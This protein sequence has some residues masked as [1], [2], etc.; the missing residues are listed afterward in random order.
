[1]S[2]TALVEI[3]DV[4]KHFH[5]RRDGGITALDGVSLTI[6]PGESFGLVGESGSGKSTL[7]RCALRL[8][9][10]DSGTISFDGMDLA[11]L[12]ASRLRR[13]RARMQMVFQDPHS[14]LNR[15]YPVGSIIESPLKAHGIGSR[16]ERAARVAEMLELAQLP[17]PWRSRRP[18]ELSGGQAQ[19]VAI[20]RALALRPDF[21]VLD[22][23]VSAL[24]ASVR[25]Q[26]LNL[27][28]SLQRDLGLTY[29][30]ISHDLSVVRY[31]CQRIGVLQQGRLVELA[32]RDLLFSAPQHPYTRM[33]LDAVPVADPVRQRERMA[34]IQTERSR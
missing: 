33:L 16:A 11:S 15:R 25:A 32:D 9:T 22:E 7:G 6:A 31:L 20:A 5:A 17:A 4:S 34:R 18:A 3:H 10:P 2:A 19:R 30:F 13:L 27:L 14:S 28:A 24:D 21:V 12:P 26:V 23:A 29:L 1:M 8:E